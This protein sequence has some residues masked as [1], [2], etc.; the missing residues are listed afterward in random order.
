NLTKESVTTIASATATSMISNFLYFAMAIA[1]AG[2]VVRAY[3]KQDWSGF[4]KI[5]TLIIISMALLFSIKSEKFNYVDLVD[6]VSIGFENAILKAN[7][8]LSDREGTINLEDADVDDADSMRD[9]ATMIENKVF[10]SVIYKPYL[11]LQYGEVDEEIIHDEGVD[12]DLSY[13]NGETRI[14]T[15]L[16]ADP[17]TQ[18]GLEKRE[19]IAKEELNV[20]GNNN[21]F[22]GNGFTS[23]SYIIST[24]ITTII[25]GIVFF[26]LAL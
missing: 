16:N 7:P 6:S 11:L 9:I 13:E 22:A 15:Y 20:I 4:F 2:I 23:A 21:I 26:F 25:Q 24:I 18:K 3:I 8:T 12:A 5:L 19:D 10:D 14:T 17:Y 1:S